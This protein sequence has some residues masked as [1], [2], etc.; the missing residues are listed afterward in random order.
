MGC[1]GWGPA[2]IGDRQETWFNVRRFTRLSWSRWPVTVPAAF[3]LSPLC[4]TERDKQQQGNHQAAG[5]NDHKLVL[6]KL[7]PWPVAASG[8]LCQSCVR[9]RLLLQVHRVLASGT[10]SPTSVPFPFCPF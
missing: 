3:E 1:F 4:G 2:G 6:L 5:P 8:S 9:P 10:M 7:L